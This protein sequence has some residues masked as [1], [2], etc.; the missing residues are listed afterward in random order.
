MTQ[1]QCVSWL[2]LFALPRC[3]QE[4]GFNLVIFA[5]CIFVWCR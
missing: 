2:Y 3:I 4:T 5:I 1:Q